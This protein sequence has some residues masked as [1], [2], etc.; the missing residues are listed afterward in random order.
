MDPAD[1]G[2]APDGNGGEAPALPRRDHAGGPGQNRGRT[3]AY[4]AETAAGLPGCARCDLRGYPGPARRR[5][6][7]GGREKEYAPA[8]RNKAGGLTDTEQISCRYL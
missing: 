1:T 5:T 2:D 8:A 3:P 4:Q 7:A 6:P